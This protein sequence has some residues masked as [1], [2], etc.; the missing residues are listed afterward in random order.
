MG[1]DRRS[2]GYGEQL[3]LR[4]SPATNGREFSG[5]N[6]LGSK[7]AAESVMILAEETEADFLNFMK[8]NVWA[9]LRLPCLC[10]G[11]VCQRDG[12]LFSTL[13]RMKVRVRLSPS[14]H[15]PYSRLH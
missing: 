13:H 15:T 1:V 3:P 5:V 2:A 7:A 14:A 12:V 9:P 6:I 11:T 4:A 8:I 10:R